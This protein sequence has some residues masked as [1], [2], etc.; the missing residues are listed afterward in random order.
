MVL[1]ISLVCPQ[2]V[3]RITDSSSTGARGPTAAGAATSSSGPSSASV[4]LLTPALGEGWGQ[5]ASCRVALFWEG[6][7]R[8][9]MVTKVKHVPLKAVHQADGSRSMCVP[10]Y[11]RPEGIC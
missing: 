9:A 11:V 8:Y 7:Q 5:A 6:S 1:S 10:Y 2:V 3:T 4:G